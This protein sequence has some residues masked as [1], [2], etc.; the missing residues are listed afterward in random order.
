MI[1]GMWARSAMK[2]QFDNGATVIYAGSGAIAAR[3]LVYHSFL[4]AQPQPLRSQ[5][6]GGK[7]K[8]TASPL[9]PPVYPYPNHH[10][11]RVEF[12]VARAREVPLIHRRRVCTGLTCAGIDRANETIARETSLNALQCITKRESGDIHT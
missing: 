7:Y 8:G 12:R 6:P 11:T 5:L 3:Q 10:V 4:S 2:H 1:A 9:P